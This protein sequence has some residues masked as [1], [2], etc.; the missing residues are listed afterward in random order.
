MKCSKCGNELNVGNKYCPNCGDKVTVDQSETASHDNININIQN[1]VK[2]G[3][4]TFVGIIIGVIVLIVI[5]EIIG[6]YSSS[7]SIVGEWTHE[8]GMIVEFFNDK[9]WSS[10]DPN[11][12]SN[13]NSGYYETSE[14]GILTIFDSYHFVEER[15]YYK[16]VGKIMYTSDTPIQNNYE[17]LE[18][19]TRK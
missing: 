12:Y 14:N 2:V 9:T 5:I 3:K 11:D 1:K 8:S 16:I 6:V 19:Y 4:N 18:Y 13:N 17:G 15:L 7:K 10:H